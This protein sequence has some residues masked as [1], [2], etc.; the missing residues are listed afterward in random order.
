MIE[1]EKRLRKLVV[2]CRE[3]I[4]METIEKERSIRKRND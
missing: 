4:E 1:M 2:V 3:T